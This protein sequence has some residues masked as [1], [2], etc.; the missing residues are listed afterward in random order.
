M[1]VVLL[2]LV[3]LAS[4]SAEPSTR[5]RGTAQVA[6]KGAG[7]TQVINDLNTAIHRSSGWTDDPSTTPYLAVYNDGDNKGVVFFNYFDGFQ[8]P[9][10]YEGGGSIQKYD[11]LLSVRVGTFW[12]NDIFTPSQAYPPVGDDHVPLNPGAPGP[13]DDSVE[14][15]K[16]A[17]VGGVMWGGGMGKQYDNF[18]NI[19][20]DGW[21][22]A[23]AFYPHDSNAGDKRCHY[24]DNHNAWECP[25]YWCDVHADGTSDCNPDASKRGAGQDFAYGQGCHFNIKE[26]FFDQTDAE[27]G[28]ENLVQ[29]YQCQC[30]YQ[31]KSSA[32]ADAWKSWVDQWRNNAVQKVQDPAY[33]WFG[34]A[35]SPQYGADYAACWMN[36]PRDMILLQNQLWWSMADWLTPEGDTDHP[37]PPIDTSS[38]ASISYWGW[39]EVVLDPDVINDPS[40]W[41]AVAI[42]LPAGTFSLSDLTGDVQSNLESQFSAY[43]NDGKLATGLD[44]A[45][46][47]PGSTVVVVKE[48]MD[49]SQTGWQK[50][51]FCEDW[52]GNCFSVNY[53]PSND[54]CYL[55]TWC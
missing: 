55:D 20:S 23:W 6:T 44:N 21:S 45:G 43:I 5:L 2:P 37:S 52:T 54:A 15:F 34:S 48:F 36:N 49:D 39:N 18:D 31:L 38:A 35:L 33:N 16:F 30:N 24:W 8:P 40:N 42:K 12:H 22:S 13:N 29:D 9:L 10:Y 46:N 50:E 27:V 1:A 25:G 28:G 4:A 51:F 3:L 32:Y 11:T 7:Y 53:D 19:Q 14:P 47:R 26:G 41:D 17:V